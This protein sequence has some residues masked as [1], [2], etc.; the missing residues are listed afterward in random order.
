MLG[1]RALTVYL[2]QRENRLYTSESDVCRYQIL[3]YK[4]GP[5]TEI[6]IFLMVVEP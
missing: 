4:D 5:H 2:F 3:K 6:K 1:S